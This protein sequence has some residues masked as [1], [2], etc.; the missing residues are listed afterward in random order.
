[1]TGFSLR[2]TH[3]IIAIGIVGLTG[4]VTFGAIYKFGSWSRR[5]RAPSLPKVVPSPT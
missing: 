1:M 5:H 4:L 2:L 3:K